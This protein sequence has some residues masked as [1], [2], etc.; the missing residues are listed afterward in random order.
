MQKSTT[1]TTP[2]LSSSQPVAL[3]PLRLKLVQL[4]DQLASL[5]S[6]L[7]AHSQ[8]TATPTTLQPGIPP[9][10]DLL[11]RFNILLSHTIGLRDLLSSV[12]EEGAGKG[13]GDKRKEGWEANVV[14]PGVVVD[15]S[16]DWLVGMLLRTKQV[17]YSL[18]LLVACEAD[19][20]WIGR[21]C[22]PT[23]VPR[24]EGSIYCKY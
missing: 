13:K 2:S 18:L 8:S 5:Q 14:V 11:S 22:S 20:V 9:F 19:G 15:E 17:S 16:R 4:I 7:Y 3:D 23:V 1:T 10:A 24:Y 12:G 6:Q 21:S